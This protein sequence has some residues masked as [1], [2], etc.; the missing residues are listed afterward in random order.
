MLTSA[1]DVFIENQGTY[2]VQVNNVTLLPGDIMVIPC[3]DR[4][5]LVY[6]LRVRFLTVFSFSQPIA[7]YPTLYSGR[8]LFIAFT[9]KIG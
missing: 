1:T 5:V 8:R 6:R 7:S 4:G 9:E 3:P 2:N